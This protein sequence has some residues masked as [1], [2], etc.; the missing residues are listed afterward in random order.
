[1]MGI[2]MP[3]TCWAYKKYNR[4]ISIIYLVLIL[5]LPN[6]CSRMQYL[7][8]VFY[9][10]WWICALKAKEKVL[11]FFEN[12]HLNPSQSKILPAF[13]AVS[14]P[15]ALLKLT[16]FIFSLNTWNVNSKRRIV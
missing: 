9:L 15:N 4:I 10:S 1:M 13:V 8:R 12:V 5:Q 14:R 11:I 6:Y 7:T 2:V 16:I 3:E